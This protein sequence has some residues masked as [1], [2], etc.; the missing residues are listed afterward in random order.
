MLLI[1]WLTQRLGVGNVV[2]QGRWPI[3]MHRH[4]FMN[5]FRFMALS[6]LR[7]RPC[8]L[9]LLCQQFGRRLHLHHIDGVCRLLAYLACL[10]SDIHAP[11]LQRCLALLDLLLHSSIRLPLYLHWHIV[12]HTMSLGPSAWLPH[13]ALYLQRRCESFTPLG[14]RPPHRYPFDT[15][16]ATSV[17]YLLRSY[18]EHSLP[19]MAEFP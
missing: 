7:V 1:L 14:N 16:T 9:A 8:L 3:V 2:T 13:L 12:L 4:I 11:H 10:G 17:V 6:I 5:S 15:N 19:Q 18:A